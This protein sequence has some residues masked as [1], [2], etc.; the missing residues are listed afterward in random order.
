MTITTITADKTK[1]IGISNKLLIF[2]VKSFIIAIVRKF[3]SNKQNSDIKQLSAALI[4]VL[5]IVNN[6]QTI[7]ETAKQHRILKD[8]DWPK[9]ILIS[10]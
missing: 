7:T 8:N 5:F 6:E 4:L 1:Q 3:S 10:A 2:S 9:M